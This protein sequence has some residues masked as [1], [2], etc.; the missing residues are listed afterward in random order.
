MSP[1]DVA[2]KFNEITD[3]SKKNDYP[4]GGNEL[5]AKIVEFRQKAKL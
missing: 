4:T 1:E 5:Y 3:F 2:S